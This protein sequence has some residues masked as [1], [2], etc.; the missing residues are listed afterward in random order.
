MCEQG[1]GLEGGGS[2]T[3]C[4]KAAENGGLE[5]RLC[6]S[7]ALPS[8]LLNLSFLICKV[9]RMSSPQPPRLW[10][11]WQDP[12][13]PWHTDLLTHSLFSA[14]HPR[15]VFPAGILQPPFFS[16]EQPQALNFGG[17]GMVIGHEIT[18]GFDDN[19]RGAAWAVRAAPPVTNTPLH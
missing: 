13:R 9:G 11:K 4:P 15:A 5:S 1:R 19:G 6:H 18:H 17:I 3:L 7:L 14:P 2:Q 10:V 8:G 16:K 12:Q